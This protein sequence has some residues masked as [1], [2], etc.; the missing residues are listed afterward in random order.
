MVYNTISYAKT[1]MREFDWEFTATLLDCN[2]QEFETEEEA[3]AWCEEKLVELIEN[4]YPIFSLFKEQ[5]VEELKCQESKYSKNLCGTHL[6]P[7]KECKKVSVEK[8]QLKEVKPKVK[9]WLCKNDCGWNSDRVD[10]CDN[11]GES[12]EDKRWVIR[13]TPQ[14][15]LIQFICY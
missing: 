1:K 5:P 6:T 12:K 7:L 13:M 2:Q 8:I 9:G 14:L 10:K 3:K 11:C 4:I 15:K